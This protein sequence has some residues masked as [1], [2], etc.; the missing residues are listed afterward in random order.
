MIYAGIGSRSTPPPVQVSM[1]QIACQLENKRYVLRSG[2]A[3]GADQAF[4]SG[5][6]YSQFKQIFLASDATSDSIILAS[7]FHPAWNNC[8]Q[9]AR[10]LHGRN[11]M[12]ILGPDLKSPVD[13]VLFWSLDETKGGTSMGIQIAKVYGIP[14]YNLRTTP[15]SQIH[16]LIT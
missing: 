16:S 14:T 6:K 13:F 7:S 12:I 3:K 1:T 15:L 2:G 8:N 4:E 10:Q 11:A 9:Y 5:V